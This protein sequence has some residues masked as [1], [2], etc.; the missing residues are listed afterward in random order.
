MS[1]LAGAALEVWVNGQAGMTVSALDRGL[2]FGDG[3]FESI[4]CVGGRARF[5]RLHLE[6]LGEGCARLSIP[7]PPAETLEAVVRQLAQ[8]DERAMLK[9][10]VTRGVAASRGY[11]PSCDQ[12]ATWIALRYHFPQEEHCAEEGVAV[13]TLALR[14]GEN[15]ALAG[16]KHCNRLE[17]V[18][19]RAELARYAQPPFEGLL[20]SRSG[21]LVSGTMTNVFLVRD[22][23]LLTPSVDRCGVAGIMRR[24]VLEEADRLGMAI[25]E[26]R[27]EAAELSA[28]S[29]MFLTNARLGVLA[30]SGIDGRK[31]AVGPLTRRLQAALAP[32]L[33]M[34]ADAC[35]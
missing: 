26:G 21:H 33:T 31:V 25:S 11:A 4:A 32:R 24:V 12:P 3:V 18:L 7:T 15:P 23:R 16:M 6:R 8:R 2:H 34:T 27:F 13:R 29:E 30:V 22:G 14:L 5:L 1:A 9:L 28:A 19:A 17:Q 20:F 10:I 35:V